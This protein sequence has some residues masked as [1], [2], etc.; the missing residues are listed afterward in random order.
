MIYVVG[1]C[2]VGKNSLTKQFKTS[3]YHG[4]Y[5]IDLNGSVEEMEESVSVM[6]DG[7]ESRL[8]FMP[9]DIENVKRR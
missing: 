1:S 4:T 5:D 2:G 6:L 9:L 8:M 7:V 3:E